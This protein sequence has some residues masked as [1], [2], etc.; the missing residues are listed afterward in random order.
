[1]CYINHN[2]SS[3][4]VISVIMFLVC[5][6]NKEMNDNIIRVINSIAKRKNLNYSIST[7][8][9]YDANFY[10]EIYKKVE[11][12]IYILDIVTPSRNGLD[13]ARLIRTKDLNNPIIFL[14]GF[15][16]E[17]G[18]VILKN[19][20]APFYFVAKE[21]Y[22]EQE[23]TKFIKTA[24]NKLSKLIKIRVFD[25]RI[26]YTIQVKDI[27]YVTRDTLTRKTVIITD[28]TEIKINKPLSY[29][30]DMLDNNFIQTHRA[31]FI[32]QNRAVIINA[33]KKTIVFDNKLTISLISYNYIK[34]IKKD[35]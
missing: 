22:W 31:C 32:N 34:N 15:E 11:D 2:P 24:L 14:T 25:D 19:Q 1:M 33:N 6:D 17:F 35:I 13:V 20:F 30:I 4:G 27:L 12:R 26:I 21:S 23:L 18:F 9:D 3:I 16:E 29:V 8:Y 7:H 5:E 28:Y 10:K